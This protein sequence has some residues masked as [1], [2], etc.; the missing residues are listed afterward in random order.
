MTHHTA[1][2]KGFFGAFAGIAILACGNGSNAPDAGASSCPASVSGFTPHWVDPVK[3]DNVC[4]PTE[5]L[6]LLKLC[7]STTS[8]AVLGSDAGSDTCVKCMFPP[9]GKLLPGQ[10]SAG[11]V[12]APP[13]PTNAGRPTRANVPGCVALLDPAALT[14]A[15]AMAAF[16]DC[17]DVACGPCADAD[18]C[19]SGAGATACAAFAPS[20]DCMQEVMAGA[21]FCVAKNTPA[22]VLKAVSTAFCGP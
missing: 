20:A 6:A 21:T 8:C 1:R 4:M 15:K 7:T 17:L 22:G 19:A 16:Q 14:C 11:P 12:N 13:D 5:I 2:A 10:D 18:A 3:H 9:D